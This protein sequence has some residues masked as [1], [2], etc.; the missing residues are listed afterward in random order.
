MAGSADITA[1]LNDGRELILFWLSPDHISGFKEFIAG[2]R[3]DDIAH[4]S[5][6]LKNSEQLDRW[7]KSME[8]GELFLLASRDPE[9]GDRLAGY[10]S[11]SLGRG[12]CSHM[13]QVE[14]LLHP[15]YCEL[16]LGSTLIKEAAGFASQRG[17]DFLEAQIHVEDRALMD[18]LKNLGFELKAIIEDYRKDCSGKAYDVIIMLKRLSYQSKKEFLYRY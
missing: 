16:G 3:E 14:A 12:T 4:L 9:A 2:L 13:A 11:L 8:R 5:L 10:C 17:L 15:D 18:S 6:N 1:I 7:L